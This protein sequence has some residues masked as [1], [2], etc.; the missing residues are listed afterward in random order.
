MIKLKRIY[1]PP[2][3]ADGER[4]LV[5]R[6]WARGL[7]KEKARLDSW[8]KEVAPSSEL[9]KWYSHDVDKWK[10]FRERYRKELKSAGKQ[11][12]IQEL[13]EK[14]RHG[15]LTLLYA[16]HDPDHNSALVLRDLL[17]SRLQ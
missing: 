3:A 8:M 4:V 12:L 16:A 13:L 6:L 14:A 11:P 17:E 10:E 15:T 9:R 1:E 5:E 7:T 2:E